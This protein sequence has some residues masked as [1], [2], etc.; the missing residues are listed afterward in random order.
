[1]S[2]TDNGSGVPVSPLLDISGAAEFFG[3]SIWWVLKHTS[4]KAKPVIPHLRIGRRGKI[5]FRQKDLQDFL[6]GFTRG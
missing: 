6:D 4:G 1:M 5:Q 2:I 3:R